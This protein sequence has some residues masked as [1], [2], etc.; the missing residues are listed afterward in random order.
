MTAGENQQIRVLHSFPHKIGAQRICTIA[1]H[2]VAGV[3]SAGADVLAFPGV[4]HKQLPAEIRV[5]PTLARG[6]FR[7]PYRVLGRRRALVLHDRVVANRLRNI[8]DEVDVVHVW[9]LAAKHT[10]KVA[11]RLGIPTVLERPNAHT[12]FAYSVVRRECERLDVTLPRN[13]EHAYNED[14][15]RYEEEEY[16]LAD[17]LLCPSDFVVKTFVDEGFSPDKLL[18][19][20]Y[21]F[22]PG[23]YFP[24][25]GA[26][27]NTGGLMVLFVGVAA[28]RKGVHFALEA[29]LRSPASREGKLLIA[30]QFLP[31]YR[32]RLSSLLD[33]PSVEVLGYRHD[34]ADLM[35]SADAL[36]L[37]S[38]EEGSA[39]VCAEAMACGCVPLVSE[40]A[41]GHCRH[42]ENS[43]V[44]EPGDV[45][46]LTSHLTLI[47]EDGAELERLRR[48]AL[49]SAATATWQNAGEV[50]LGAYR[51]AIGDHPGRA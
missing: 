30:G 49:S 18:R 11:A 7:I 51:Q 27:S 12:H 9:P 45:D 17:F 3:S 28:V 1:W 29:W 38:L 40:V 42:M 15:L 33:H 31:D 50:L 37:P 10:L 25:A 24:P 5:R 35:R 19:H 21:G 26:R 48:G 46:T 22:D 39:L 41:S 43:L 23:I 16:R 8:A 6:R 14:I 34:V 13:H 47:H 4:V 36:V 20:S 32:Q 2:Q 44:H